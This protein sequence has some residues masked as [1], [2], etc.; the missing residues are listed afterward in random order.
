MK[1]NKI[2]ILSV[3]LLMVC[4]C[5]VE[6]NI[7]IKDNKVSEKIILPSNDEYKEEN[8]KEN[9]YYDVNN[10]RRYD[11]KI[12]NNNIILTNK[13]TSFSELKNNNLY[14]FCFSRIET[15]ETKDFYALGT[16]DDFNCMVYEYQDINEIKIVLNTF[17]KVTEHNADE[18]KFGKYIWYFDKYNYKNKRIYFSV[19]K[20][21]YL[22]YYRLRGLVIGLGTVLIVIVVSA[23]IVKIFKNRSN[24]EN[25][26]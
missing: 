1:K 14:N 25:K 19:K 16:S 9:I 4:G 23:I 22:W 26:I 3:L 8:L 5:D 12:K 13:K 2:L 24:L 11:L 21:D 10:K 15:T 20:N 18:T 7:N 6:Y 17:N